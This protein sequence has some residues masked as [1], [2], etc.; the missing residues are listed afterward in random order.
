MARPGQELASRFRGVLETLEARNKQEALRRVAFLQEATEARRA[1][2]D[3]LGAFAEAV[4]HLQV[5]AKSHDDGLTIRYQDR[6]LHFV[7]I[8][9]ADRIKVH[10]TGA[11]QEEHRVYREAELGNRWVLV[12]KRSG[13][14]ERAPL[15]DDGLE[16]LL[17]RALELPRPSEVRDVVPVETATLEDVIP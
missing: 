12:S 7:P 9:E 1:L 2:L 8:G 15:F 11:D 6:F 14:E 4:G 5:Q 10:F 16:E 13:R 3:D 17:V